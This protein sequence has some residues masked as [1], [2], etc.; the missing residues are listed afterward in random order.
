MLRAAAN[1][2]NSTN[3]VPKL[4][5]LAVRKLLSYSVSWCVRPWIKLT[6]EYHFN[7]SS[8]TYTPLL[9]RMQ[10]MKKHWHMRHSC[11]NSMY[12]NMKSFKTST[13]FPR[14]FSF[15]I[16]Q[17][18]RDIQGLAS[19]TNSCIIT[20]LFQTTRRNMS[21]CLWF[22]PHGGSAFEYNAEVKMS[23]A[24][25][26]RKLQR[27]SGKHGESQRGGQLNCTANLLLTTFHH[28]PVALYSV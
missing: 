25:P 27:E 26:Q 8:E 4:H 7:A 23:T 24:P 10:N 13:Y 15:F 17:L 5:K 21:V 1:F 18:H 16:L 6:P 19:S 14:F 3:R 28:C 22:T 12:M 11:L 20:C 9:R 2:S